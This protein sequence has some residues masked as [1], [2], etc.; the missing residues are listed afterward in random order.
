MTRLPEAVKVDI[1][2]VSW[3]RAHPAGDSMRARVLYALLTLLTLAC[4][5]RKEAPVDTLPT[6]DTGANGGTTVEALCDTV[7][8]LCDDHWGWGDAAACYAGWLGEGEDWACAD[9]GAYLI[10]AEP[11]P[12][13]SDCDAFGACETSCWDQHC[14]GG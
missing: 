10:C 14:A 13:A 1:S 7:F 9:P 12:E 5:A 11:C 3:D 4:H 6:D 8:A 2:E